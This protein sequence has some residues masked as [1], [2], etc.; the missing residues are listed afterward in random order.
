MTKAEKIYWKTEMNIRKAIE[1]SK[2]LEIENPDVLT[3]WEDENDLICKRTLN[4]LKKIYNSK[5]RTLKTDYK[6]KIITKEEAL[7]R[8]EINRIMYNT[9]C[10]Y[11][12]TWF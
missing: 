9:I 11:E 8:K 12:R 7:M 3:M 1:D 2:E 10:K 4:E 6:C 5:V